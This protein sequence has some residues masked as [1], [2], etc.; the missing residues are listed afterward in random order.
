MKSPFLF[1]L[2]LIVIFQQQQHLF[3]NQQFSVESCSA[4]SGNG[5][6]S[7]DAGS[8]LPP[9]KHSLTLSDA[10]EEPDDVFNNTL[11]TTDGAVEEETLDC[12]LGGVMN[13]DAHPLQKKQLQHPLQQQVT[14]YQI[15]KNK[16]HPMNAEH[17]NKNG[18]VKMGDNG[19]VAMF[20]KNSVPSLPKVD[21]ED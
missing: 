13:S 21:E 20:S 12:V 18:Y 1:I 16:Q 5:S 11:N 19:M 14:T 3:Y 2:Q 7:H 6:L 4:D 15:D 10:S 9:R 8:T 17:A